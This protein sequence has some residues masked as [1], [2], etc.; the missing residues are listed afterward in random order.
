MIGRESTC[1]TLF[2]LLFLHI[3]L[4]IGAFFTLSFDALSDIPDLLIFLIGLDSLLLFNVNMLSEPFHLLLHNL[5][6]PHLFQL[7]L[8]I[9]SQ[10]L[11][12]FESQLVDEQD[13]GESSVCL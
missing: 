6:I 12:F 7:F 8:G 11:L 13:C 1:V 9:L 5:F 3:K 4:S 10:C 2:S